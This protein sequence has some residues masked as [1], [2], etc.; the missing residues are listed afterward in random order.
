MRNL[1][2]FFALACSALL[3][4][5]CS[6]PPPVPTKQLSDGTQE[7]SIQVKS[8]YHPSIIE[9]KPDKPLILKFFRDEATGVHSCDQELSIPSQKLKQPLPAQKEVSITIPPQIKGAE[10]DFECG[11]KMMKGKIRYKLPS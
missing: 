4:S 10:V 7:I 2:T 3:L 9:A 1:F 5:A 8:G 11:M 6:E